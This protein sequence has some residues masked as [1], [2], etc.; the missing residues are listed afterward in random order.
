MKRNE[1]REAT[2]TANYALL[3][4]PCFPPCPTERNPGFHR[5]RSRRRRYAQISNVWCNLCL[6]RGTICKIIKQKLKITYMRES[7]GRWM[8]NN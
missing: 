2:D 6:R 4:P 3:P 8:T 1:S 5:R 7:E